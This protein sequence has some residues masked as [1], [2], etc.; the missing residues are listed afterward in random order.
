MS[1]LQGTLK[2]CSAHKRKQQ[3]PDPK[4]QSSNP[5]INQEKPQHTV[6]KMRECQSIHHCLLPLSGTESRPSPWDSFQSPSYVLTLSSW[7][8][9]TSCTSSGSFPTRDL[10]FHVPVASLNIRGS[11]CQEPTGGPASSDC[12]HLGP[13]C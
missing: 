4:A 9:S 1:H 7:C 2:S 3:F 5:H 6:S 13:M 11:D 10:L 8:C 12:T